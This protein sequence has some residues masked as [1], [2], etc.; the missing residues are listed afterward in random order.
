QTSLVRYTAITALLLLGPWTPLLFQGQEFGSTTSFCFFSDVGDDKLKEAV[1]KGRFE[2]LAQFPSSAG[3]EI[4]ARI[5]VPH[6][7]R[8]F[9]RSKLDWSERERN[10]SLCYLHRDLL[11]VG[12][13]DSRLSREIVGGVGS[14]GMGV[15]SVGRR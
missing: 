8:T 1:R 7:P 4:Q 12:R 10:G 13:E 14:S 15:D 11:R 6:D 3:E 5:G 9:A 2:F